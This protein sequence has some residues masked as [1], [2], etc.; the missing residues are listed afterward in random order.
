MYLIAGLGNPEKKYIGTRHNTGFAAVEALCEKLGGLKLNETKF[1]G[2]YTKARVMTPAGPEQLIIVKPLTYMNLSGNCIAPLANFY[3]IPAEQVI[4]VS[5]DINLAV[6]RM[7]IRKGGSAGGHTGLKSIIQC[8]GT[9]QFP[10]VRVGVGKKPEYMDLADH[11]LAKFDRN[12]AAVMA[13]TYD[14]V[15][16]AILDIVNQGVEHAMNHYNPMNCA[17]A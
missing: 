10:R 5:D 1:Q 14:A 9:D 11:V 2:V 7:R 8:L 4:V 16:D 6:G 15:A 17:Q 3:K 12:D 13:T